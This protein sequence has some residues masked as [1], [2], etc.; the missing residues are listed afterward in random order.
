LPFCS[1]DYRA[2][3]AAIAA[4]GAKVDLRFPLPLARRAGPPV[5]FM[6]DRKHGIGRIRLVLFQVELAG[7]IGEIGEAVGHR[8]FSILAERT[9]GIDP[10]PADHGGLPF[11]IRAL[12]AFPPAFFR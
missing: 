4:L 12:V 7:Y 10:G 6:R 9:A 8:D 3:S 2:G 1:P 11:M 5:F